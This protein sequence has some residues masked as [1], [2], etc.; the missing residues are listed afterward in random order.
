MHADIPDPRTGSCRCSLFSLAVTISVFASSSECPAC[1]MN[2]ARDT[3]ID[4]VA[5]VL[6][7]FAHSQRKN[8][9]RVFLQCV[10]VCLA[11]KLQ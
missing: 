9:T 1:M 5:S 11:P 7:H 10:T 4:E 8:C 2:T 3:F 6:T